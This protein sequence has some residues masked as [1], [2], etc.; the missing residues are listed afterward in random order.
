[1]I[2]SYLLKNPIQTILAAALA[3]FAGYHFVQCSIYEAEIADYKKVV[4]QVEANKKVYDI[5][6]KRYGKNIDEISKFYND[7]IYDLEHAGEGKDDE[8]ENTGRI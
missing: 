2:E 5:N 8:C 4:A 7:R 1:M 6:I 3:I